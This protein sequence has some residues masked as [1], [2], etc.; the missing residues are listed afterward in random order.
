[1]AKLVQ[2]FLIQNAFIPQAKIQ[3]YE[4]GSVMTKREPPM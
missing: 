4:M 1:V 3:N 2:L